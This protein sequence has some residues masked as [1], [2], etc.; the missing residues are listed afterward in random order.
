MKKTFTKSFC[1]VVIGIAAM[2][3]SIV[4]AQA[5]QKTFINR[6]SNPVAKIAPTSIINQTLSGGCDTVNYTKGFVSPYQWSA[7]IW[8]SIGSG[9]GYIN[10]IN[11][12]GDKEKGNFLDL[13]S[14]TTATHITG[15][16]LWFAYAYSTNLTKTV[17]V[18]VYDDGGTSGAPGTLLGSQNL[19]MST[20]AN[21]ANGGYITKLAFATP[22]A[23]PASK[24][25]YITCDFTNLSWTNAAGTDSMSL[26]SSDTLEENPGIAW[27]KTSANAW[28]PMSSSPGWNLKQMALYIMPF[29]TNNITAASAVNTPTPANATICAGASVTFNPTGTVAPFGSHWGASTGYSSASL[30]G[31]NLVVTYNNA[32]T[33]T[34]SNYANGCGITSKA[35]DTVHV[36]PTPA[37]TT[38]ANFS[39]CKGST[40][41]KQLFTTTPGGATIS[42]ISSNTAVGLAASGTDSVPTFMATNAANTTVITST[43][44]V[45]ALL[46]GC[47]GTSSYTIGVK[48]VPVMSAIANASACNHTAVVSTAFASSP[49]GS[50][51]AWTN[52]NATIGLAA[53]GTG[54]LPTFTATTTGTSVN[55][56]TI[57][58]TP[59]LNACAGNAGSFTF[60]VNPLPAINA[61]TNHDTIC[62]GSSAL[63]NIGGTGVAYLWT[64]A[65]GL[66]SATVASPTASPTATTS[67]IAT[68]TDNNAC[69]GID[70]V[71]IVVKNCT[72]INTLSAAGIK[73]AFDA[74]SNQYSLLSYN[75]T[76]GNA[77]IS[78]YNS[79]GQEVQHAVYVLNTDRTVIHTDG[80]SA[81]IYYVKCVLNNTGFTE[82][83]LVK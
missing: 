78:I 18:K 26:V 64:P 79:L 32:G 51:Y 80:L 77:N 15:A 55:T 21:D 8:N 50:T 54:S 76:Y 16:Y 9:S 56:G 59:T 82:K 39:V 11:S 47:T 31:S 29:I 30:N 58:V 2:A 57:T 61:S 66:S 45:S 10:G 35:T 4:P 46:N 81:G 68:I 22:I 53:N 28:R 44:A 72:G 27:E 33:Y 63:L 74:S 42:W 36:K 71:K 24:K 3:L 62:L 69:Q 34:V 49:T 19:T 83:M 48:P 67:Y 12:S 37:I 65:T 13:S 5:Q 73:I 25:I 40:V 60:T 20:I 43:V 75:T 38:V 1:S 6:S 14:Y 7:V 23:I 41:P 70:T 17:P 52:S